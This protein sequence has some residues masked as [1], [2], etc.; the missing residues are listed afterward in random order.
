MERSFNTEAFYSP[1]SAGFSP[2]FQ[3]FRTA[4]DDN[5]TLAA[6][7]FR[8]VTNGFVYNLGSDDWAFSGRITYLPIYEED[9]RRLIHVGASA[10]YTG[11]NANTVTYRVRGPERA[12]PST[13]WP[14]YAN[15]SN[16]LGDTQTDVNFEL[17]SV[18][19]PLSLQSEYNMNYVS[20]ASLAGQPGV[21][22][23]FYHGGYVEVGF[24]LTGEHRQYVK[25]A[26]LFDRVVPRENAYLV[27]TEQG[28]WS[29]KGA[30]QIAG[31]YN[32]LD[33]NDKGINGGILNDYTMGL[34]WYI[35]PNIK[36]QWNLSLT[37][38][39]SPTG[40]TNDL[41]QGL[42]MRVAHDF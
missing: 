32:F 17:V 19:G 3:V 40:G 2:G 37:Q 21:G 36:V 4:L 8:N 27:Q 41:I 29:G 15:I 5:M 18:L 34:N 38:R 20:D 23:L 9:G 13:L 39:K 35:N 7:A 14:R 10:R 24:F 25:R 16:I 31:R 11:L 1:F 30:W 28:R 42:G 6:G 12:G 26:A 22:T 33:L